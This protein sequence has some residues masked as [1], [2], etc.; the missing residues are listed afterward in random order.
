MTP[1]LLR[2][3]AVSKQILCQPCFHLTSPRQIPS[4]APNL[5]IFH[6]S[7]DRKRKKRASE[8]PVAYWD[9]NQPFGFKKK[10]K[11]LATHLTCAIL[12]QN[13]LEIGRLYSYSHK[14]HTMKG[15]S[16]SIYKLGGRLNMNISRAFNLAIDNV[17][18]D[19][20]TDVELF[21]RPFEI[22]MLKNKQFRQ[23]VTK[24][25][26]PL[27]NRD[28][29]ELEFSPLAHCLVPKKDFFSF[30]KCALVDPI[31]EIKYL[32]M[33]IMIAECIEK[34]RDRR[35]NKRIF[36]YRWDPSK[37]HLFSSKYNFTAF[38]NHVKEKSKKRHVNVIAECDIANFYDRINLHRLEC[39]LSSLPNIDIKI[40]K[41]IDLLLKFW[42]NRDSYGLP[43]GSNAS[44]ILAEA[45]LIEVDKYLI[46]QDVSFCR[47]VDDFRF[48]APDAAT[49]HYWLSLLVSRL[50]K[51]GLFINTSKTRLRDVSKESSLLPNSSP[52][53][54][55][56][57]SLNKQKK[58]ENTS[59]IIRGYSGLIP[60]KFRKLTLNE[61]AKY[62]TIKLNETLSKI[63]S[64]TLIDPKEFV[65][66]LKACVAQRK[67][68]YLIKIITLINK[69]PQ[70]IP[71]V[72]DAILKNI[73]IF[74]KKEKDHISEQLNRDWLGNK[75]CSEYIHISIVK[76]LGDPKV[77]R[78]DL[79]FSFF[80]RL[81]RNQG[82]Y[83]GRAVLE[84]ITPLVDRG[85]VLEVRD[86]FIRADMWEKRQIAKM[87]ALHLIEDEQKPFFKNIKPICNDIYL[88]FIERT[89]K[90]K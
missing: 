19:G 81:T 53:T 41:K 1:C 36:S 20:T 72:L 33:V 47:F 17:I 50:N 31:D 35:N 49:A 70:F 67:R 85:E 34:N 10:E 28:F 66:F 38:R 48:F 75:T 76:F 58:Q 86:Y 52:I 74:S 15:H 88:P 65:E 7:L 22:D 42:A 62:K 63:D 39:I 56:Q 4:A 23:E 8:N 6:H 83:I 12:V 3:N 32:S 84:Q 29:N 90:K 43:V 5:Y 26:K 59:R 37:G 60:T 57:F 40:V 68:N 64:A 55:F 77:A 2:S 45:A 25:I 80:R 82:N 30:R 71:L 11:S 87:V 51:E 21:S 54:F 14:N 89:F 9:N 69:F 16:Q 18:Q 73:D 27:L 79:L 24:K 46:S 61:I 13:E 78:K 44:R